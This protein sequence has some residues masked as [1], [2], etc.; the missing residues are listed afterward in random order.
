MDKPEHRYSETPYAKTIDEDN[1]GCLYPDCI[2]QGN[3]ITDCN[4]RTPKQRQNNKV[5]TFQELLTS[6][7][8]CPEAKEWAS[9]KTWEEAYKNCPR[10]DWMLWLFQKTNPDNLRELT[11]AKGH[12]ANTIRHLI[13]DERSTQAMDTAIAFGEGRA[14]REELNSAAAAAHAAALATSAAHAAAAYA[15][16]AYAAA[17]AA[18]YSANAYASAAASTAAYASAAAST[19]AYAAAADA[20]DAAAAAFAASAARKENLQLTADICR[21]YLPIE[22]WKYK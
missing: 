20:A 9:D 8:A 4:N 3:E 22:I 5:M 1:L 13:K 18:A 12:C 17:N 6:L 14:T 7:D 15:S 11:L 16:A 2:C 21:K 10:G 19:A